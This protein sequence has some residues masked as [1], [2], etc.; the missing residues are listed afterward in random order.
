MFRS[1]SLVPA[2]STTKTGSGRVHNCA[3]VYADAVS[4]TTDRVWLWQCFPKGLAARRLHWFCSSL[5][6]CLALWEC[7]SA[8]LDSIEGFFHGFTADALFQKA[9]CGDAGDTKHAYAD[10]SLGAAHI[11][12]FRSPWCCSIGARS[13]LVDA[14]L[15]GFMRYRFGNLRSTKILREL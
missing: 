12:F 6:C 3:I 14:I 15:E 5:S 10:G 4:L 2:G 7:W 13:H 11:I 9:E 1:R 8:V